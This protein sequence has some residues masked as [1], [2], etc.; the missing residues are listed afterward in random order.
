MSFRCTGNTSSIDL[1]S[2]PNTFKHLEIRVTCRGG[3]IDAAGSG[4]MAFYFNTDSGGSST[5]PRQLLQAY[6]STVSRLNADNTDTLY[7]GQYMRGG[8]P[9]GYFGTTIIRILNY[10][11]TSALKVVRLYGGIAGSQAVSS[12]SNSGVSIGGGL[13]EGSSGTAI[14]RIVFTPNQNHFGVNSTFSIYGIK[15]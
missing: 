4:E 9:S 15:G 8:G 13:W 3:T 7:G 6:G 5:Y 12:T 10:A 11:S 1:S 2:I 14:N